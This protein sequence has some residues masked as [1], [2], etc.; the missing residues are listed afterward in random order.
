M[1]GVVGN[2][3]VDAVVVEAAAVGLEL[4]HERD[5]EAAVELLS[6]PSATRAGTPRVDM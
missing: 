3:H 5:H 2:M 6:P 1:R 4:A